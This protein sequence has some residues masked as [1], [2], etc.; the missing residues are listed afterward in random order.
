MIGKK[1]LKYLPGALFAIAVAAS[2]MGG[3]AAAKDAA[4]AG[5]GCDGLD[6][7]ASAQAT[8]KAYADAAAKLN[9][10]AV[11]VEGKFLAV[12]NAMNADLKLDTTK[13][14]AAEACGILKARVDAAA[15]KGV[16]VTVSIEASC[17][18]D[19]HAQASCEGSC[20]ASASCDVKAKCEPGKVVVECNG[21]CDAQCD[22]QAPSFDCTGTCEG[23]CT[24][25][26]AV[27]C[28]G[29]CEGTCDA[30]KFDG[31][32]DVGARR[33]SPEPVAACA[34]VNAT[35]RKRWVRCNGKCE[36]TCSAKASGHCEAACKGKLTG[37]NAPACAPARARPRLA[38]CAPASATASAR[39]CRGRRRARASATVCARPKLPAPVHRQP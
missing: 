16:T 24:A 23:T 32:C 1:S 6:V 4:N 22:V 7:S 25:T 27:A 37:G 26:A 21:S 34:R 13:T 17:S 19:V 8:V 3:C 10:K 29:Q 30:P 2:S 33:C 18:A 14:T 15:M 31:T 38:R 39:T 5:K 36:G 9:A 28:T 35:A 12:C 20:N 11:E